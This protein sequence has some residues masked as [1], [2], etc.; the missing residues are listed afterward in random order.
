MHDR[1]PGAPGQYIM[2][3]AADQ[4][5][6]LLAGEQCTIV[7]VRDDQPI[8]VGTPYNKASVLPDDLA[9]L[10]CPDALDPTPADA[11]RALQ[12]S[13]LPAGWLPTPKEIGAATPP[14]L[15]WENASPT[16]NFSEQTISLDLSE[17]QFVAVEYR[18]N[19]D[20]DVRK[21]DFGLVGST[22][23]MDVISPSGYLG[24]RTGEISASGIKFASATYNSNTNVV[25]YVIP[26]RIYGI[27]GVS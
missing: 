7:L 26:T 21:T 24:R 18:F 20:G 25:G 4:L 10:I 5:T 2:T 16:S 6:K 27:K 22:F 17:Y 12:K 23:V 14:E 15:L 3:I 1:Q 13:K 8:A 11:F 9:A 19:T